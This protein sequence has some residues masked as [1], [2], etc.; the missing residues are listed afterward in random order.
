MDI[1]SIVHNVGEGWLLE[2]V[3]H[4][5]RLAGAEL[6]EAEPQDRDRRGKAR[7]GRFQ[8]RSI[9]SLNWGFREGRLG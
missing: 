8:S 7:S 9:T 2:L 1:G 6:T 4:L 5:H 3:D